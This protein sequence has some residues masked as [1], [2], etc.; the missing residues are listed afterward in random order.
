MTEPKAEDLNPVAFG[1]WRASA[2]PWSVSRR[3]DAALARAQTALKTAVLVNGAGVIA[4]LALFAQAFKDGGVL[5]G[6][7][8][9]AAAT[10][11]MVAGTA[12]AGCAT[13]LSFLAQYG[14][15]M[16]WHSWFGRGGRAGTIT[17][18][19]IALVFLSYAC[20]VL[21]GLHTYWALSG[22]VRSGVFAGPP[23]TAQQV[24]QGGAALGGLVAAALWFLAAK[25][26]AGAAAPQADALEDRTP[27]EGAAPVD[28]ADAIPDFTEAAAPRGVRRP[29]AWW[30][31]WAALAT[32]VA[33]LLQGL[34]LMT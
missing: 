5:P 8:Q 22:S 14:D 20:F 9:F 33:A 31:A 6:A 32:G 7:G 4:L 19:N 26:G 12:V 21:G 28:A 17:R 34:A 3:L 1:P 2:G 15:L 30:N 29:A 24:L 10:L 18:L 25:V 23:A 11:W 16:R 13:G 27:G